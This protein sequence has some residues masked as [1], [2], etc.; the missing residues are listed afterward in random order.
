MHFNKVVFLK[1]KNMMRIKRRAETKDEQD[2]PSTTTSPQDDDVTLIYIKI[3]VYENRIAFW[4][5]TGQV[6]HSN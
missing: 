3:D 5:E 2:S 4:P 1:D 6:L